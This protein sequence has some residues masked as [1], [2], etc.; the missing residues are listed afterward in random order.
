MSR[1]GEELAVSWVA[2]E[3]PFQG[4]NGSGLM[5]LDA[6]QFCDCK[7]ALGEHTWAAGDYSARVEVVEPGHSAEVEG[8]YRDIVR[9]DVDA[10][11]DRGAAAPGDDPDTGPEP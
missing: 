5:E 10:A 1:D 3:D 9:D 4:N 2:M 6:V 11:G 8:Q 7:V